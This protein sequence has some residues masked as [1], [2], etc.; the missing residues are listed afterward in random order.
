M[1]Q[2]LCSTRAL[3]RIE[4]QKL[5]EEICRSW[6]LHFYGRDTVLYILCLQRPSMGC[7]RAD[8]RQHAVNA[9][10]QRF[11]GQVPACLTQADICLERIAKFWKST[12]AVA[13]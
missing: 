12:W 2:C 5:S 4:V 13:S 11:T 9:E 1:L 7:R 8:E 6:I 10:R 3:Q